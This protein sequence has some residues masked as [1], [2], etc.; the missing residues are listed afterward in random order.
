I[1]LKYKYR[2][3]FFNNENELIQFFYE[4]LYNEGDIFY[5]DRPYELNSIVRQINRKIPIMVVLHS[6]HLYNGVI[7]S[8]YSDVFKN[9][10]S[11]KGIIVSTVK[12]K[13][14]IKEIIKNKIPVYNINVGY[15]LDE[16]ITIYDKNINNNKIISVSRLVPDKQIEHQIRIIDEVR[17]T[18]PDVHL[19]IYGHGSGMKHINKLIKEYNLEKNI[20]LHG[21]SNEIESALQEACLKIFTSKKEGFALSILESLSKG[22]PVISYD[23]DYG[24]N[25]MI[26]NGKNGY[27]IEEGNEGEMAKVIISLLKDKKKLKKLSENCYTSI[28]KFSDKKTFFKWQ[29]VINTIEQDEKI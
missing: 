5:I 29:R 2:E 1:I 4:V 13:N 16:K 23:V 14:S 8:I 12:Q 28:E 26:E 15:I 27:L 10:D 19:D 24:P 9:L 18:I 22:T 6:T 25:E 3:Y 17:Q 21:F 7:K 20:I 11:Y